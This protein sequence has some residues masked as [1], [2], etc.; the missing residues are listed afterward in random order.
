M[1]INHRINILLI[2]SK[3][4]ETSPLLIFFGKRKKLNK[5]KY[6]TDLNTKNI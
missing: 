2:A 6:A 5:E 3:N 1:K 4:N